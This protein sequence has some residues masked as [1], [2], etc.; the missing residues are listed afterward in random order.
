MLKL[1]DQMLEEPLENL[2]LLY[3]PIIFKGFRQ[4][5]IIKNTTQLF[6]ANLK[7]LMCQ[8]KNKKVKLEIIKRVLEEDIKD[9]KAKLE[10]IN[11]RELFYE[12]L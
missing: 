11:L 12:F 7:I 6:S 10:N 8:H 9:L 1:E 4:E 3:Q 2:W 5:D